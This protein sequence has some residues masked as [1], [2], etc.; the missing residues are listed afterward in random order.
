[1]STVYD[2][3]AGVL[4]N[5][6]ADEFKN[7]NDKIQSPQWSHLV[8][9]GVHKERKP[10]DVD[11]WYVRCAAIL[12]KVYISGPIGVRTLRIKYGGKKDRGV[13]PESFRMGSGSIVRGALNQLEDAGL[14][15]KVDGG[16]VVTPQ[17]Q[18]YLDKVST[19]LIKDIP[20]LEKY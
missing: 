3:P 17:G 10:V 16:R 5:H 9:T 19:E 7:N 13:N 11:W 1:M 15:E 14:V 6:L 18:S 8:K 2:V 4:I 20:E 12:R